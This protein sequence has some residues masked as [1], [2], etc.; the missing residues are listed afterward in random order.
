MNI[1]VLDDDPHLLAALRSVLHERGHEVDCA[2]EADDAAD[3]A[4]SKAYDFI[5]V[6][7]RMP[8][9]DGVWFMENTNIGRRT[10]V[11]LMTAYVNR[12]VID[13][14]FSLGACGYIIKPFDDEA[15]M[16]HLEFH[17]GCEVP[18]VSRAATG[19]ERDGRR[20]AFSSASA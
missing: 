2:S 9:H 16:R 5:L 11:L 10:R 12:R 19:D 7:Y 3:L 8:G 15:L 1:L 20:R 4:R 13:R 18:A 17:A 14:M 6:D